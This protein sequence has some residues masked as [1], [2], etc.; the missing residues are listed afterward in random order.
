MRRSH[1]ERL[2][3]IDKIKAQL[4]EIYTNVDDKRKKLINDIKLEIDN[5]REELEEEYQEFQKLGPVGWIQA[6]GIA[7]G[8]AGLV[9][10]F[11]VG[12]VF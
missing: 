9:V 6:N 12:L 10:G 8:I 4:D 2:W 11:L 3:E 7:V 1:N 5:L